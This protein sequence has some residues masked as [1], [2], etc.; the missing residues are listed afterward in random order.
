[1]NTQDPD[2]DTESLRGRI[3]TLMSDYMAVDGAQVLAGEPLAALV[4]SL[5]LMEFLM[6]VER[7]WSVTLDFDEVLHAPDCNAQ[8]LAR[9]VQ[10]ALAR[11]APYPVAIPL[12]RAVAGNPH[13]PSAAAGLAPGL[14]P[15]LAAGLPA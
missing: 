5:S 1:M 4:D 3:A 15:G 7:E 13:R 9:L 12:A 8:A 11:R 14:A 2:G 6:L 10:S